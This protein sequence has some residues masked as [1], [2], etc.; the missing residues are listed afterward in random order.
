MNKRA[1]FA[2]VLLTGLLI[3]HSAL[4]WGIIGH[5]VTGVIAEQ[6]LSGYARARLTQILGAESLAE[7]STWA[8]FM[9]SN[10]N[11]FWQKTS[12]PWHYVTVPPGKTYADV[13]APPQGDAVTALE[14]FTA[15]LKNPDTPLRDQQ[16]ALRFLVHIIGDLHQPL[17]AGNG[18]DRG[19]NQFVLS[20]HGDVTNLHSVWDVGLIEKEL[21]SHTEWVERLNAHLSEDDVIAWWDPDPLTWIAESTQIRDTI[22]PED[23]EVRWEYSYQHIETVRRRLVQAG[24]RLAA[25]LNEVFKP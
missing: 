20:F 5:R 16:L 3:S 12:S 19:G 25:Y 9:R 22:Y 24:V 17:H 7:A 14:R 21:L 18:R 1:T 8:D 15:D 23:R 6:H 4:G 10:P 2:V 11:Q 13:G